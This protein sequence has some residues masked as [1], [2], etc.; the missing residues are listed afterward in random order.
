[1]QRQ[2]L[3]NCELIF[4]LLI[5]YQTSL[6]IVMNQILVCIFLNIIKICEILYN[7]VLY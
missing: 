2:T 5:L 3:I 6:I 7:D 4:I 1:M